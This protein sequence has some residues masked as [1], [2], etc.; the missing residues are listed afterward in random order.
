MVGHLFGGFCENDA[1]LT[2]NPIETGSAFY[3]VVVRMLTGCCFKRGERFKVHL[4]SQLSVHLNRFT[5]TGLGGY[6]LPA[7][8]LFF[9]GP[10]DGFF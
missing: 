10:G 7:P 2:F 6:K 1:V 8:T 5:E 9:E 3:F 4:E